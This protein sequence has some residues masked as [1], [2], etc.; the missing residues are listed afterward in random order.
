MYLYHV[1]P[2]IEG[3]QFILDDQ[4]SDLPQG[5]EA[6]YQRHWR[7]MRDGREKEFDTVYAPIVCILGVAQEPV[8]TR[9]IASWTKLT[10]S[11]T[12]EYIG[13]WREFLKEEK[14]DGQP[15]YRIYHASFQDFLKEQV[16]LEEF[17]DMISEYY[18][19]LS[20][21]PD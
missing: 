18:L 17:D 6:Y 8:T 19:S 7:Q 4:L 21:P 2:A 9:Q 16:D 11:Q 1:L 3:G 5:L 12:K 15:H 20:H 14:K 10:P 13:L